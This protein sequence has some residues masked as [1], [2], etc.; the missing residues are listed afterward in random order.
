[1]NDLVGEGSLVPTA[2]RANPPVVLHRAP[3]EV[4]CF[5]VSAIVESSKTV[6]ATWTYRHLQ[7]VCNACREP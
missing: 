3:E 6:V 4:T 7:M 2:F 5:N 1:V